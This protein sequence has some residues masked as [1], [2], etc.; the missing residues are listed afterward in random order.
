MVRNRKEHIRDLLERYLEAE[1]SLD[2]ERELRDYFTS[3]HEVPADIL[4]GQ[5]MFG[6]FSALSDGEAPRYDTALHRHA[7]LSIPALDPSSGLSGQ[8]E[9]V[10]QSVLPERFQPSVQPGH[11][12]QPRE[13]VSDRRIMGRRIV[14]WSGWSVAAI[15]AL[16]VV[17]LSV[18]R[19]PTVYCKVNGVP[20]TDYRLAEQQAV[21]A[22]ALIASTIDDSRKCVEAL[23][24]VG[25]TVELLNTLT[26][27][28]PDNISESLDS[29]Q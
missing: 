4:Y 28:G 6:A 23:E 24:D 5:A 26:G 2:E 15:V 21:G 20:V 3:T 8:P 9:R 18:E 10:E 12:V 11:A 27:N 1:T 13:K 25:R 29:A 17:L 16:I 7:P 19:T 14:R 22:L